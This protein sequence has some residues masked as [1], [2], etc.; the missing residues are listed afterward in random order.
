MS[1]I[2]SGCAISQRNF[3]TVL[4]FGLVQCTRA[5]ELK[6]KC[7]CCCC[8]CR[9]RCCCVP[10]SL[11]CLT[12]LPCWMRL[13]RPRL[14]RWLLSSWS[15]L[16]TWTTTNTS[17]RC[18]HARCVARQGS[19]FGGG[20]ATTVVPACLPTTWAKMVAVTER[21]PPGGVTQSH[22]G[23]SPYESAAPPPIR[24]PLFGPAGAAVVWQ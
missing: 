22:F 4:Q 6:L 17:I 15:T 16:T 9:R 20:D 13:W 2:P 1:V 7:D 18:P 21:Q 24:P 14:S 8:R 5:C 10:Q 12:S 3:S 11:R 19:S 23:D